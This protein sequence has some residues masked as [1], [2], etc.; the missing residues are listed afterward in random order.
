MRSLHIRP[1]GLLAALALLG[2][3]PA[4]SIATGTGPD[5]VSAKTCHHG[6]IAGHGKRLCT[7]QR[8]ARRYKRQYRRYGFSCSKRDRRGRYHLRVIPRAKAQA[9]ALEGQYLDGDYYHQSPVKNVWVRVGSGGR[10]ITGAQVDC[11]ENAGAG[12]FKIKP[13]VTIRASGDFH[14]TTTGELANRSP[15]VLDM[16]GRFVSRKEVT[17]HLTMSSNLCHASRTFTAKWQD[18]EHPPPLPPPEQTPY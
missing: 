8:C 7:G 18:P 1:V 15:V 17:G 4:V 14:F 12:F 2:A 9:P 6:T 10:A 11:Q 5:A 16:T 3:A 13:S